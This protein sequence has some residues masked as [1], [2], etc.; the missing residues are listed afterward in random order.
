MQLVHP[1]V[2][3]L[4]WM[5]GWRLHRM[6]MLMLFVWLVGWL[7]ACLRSVLVVVVTRCFLC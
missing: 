2:L 6:Q 4:S 5:C 3:V 7:V 1:S